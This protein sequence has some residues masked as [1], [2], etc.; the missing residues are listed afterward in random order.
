MVDDGS[1]LPASEFGLEGWPE[2][3]PFPLSASDCLALCRGDAV[4]WHGT[5]DKARLLPGRYELLSGWLI[6]KR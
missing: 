2:G 4:R 1:I 6:L 3:A 5:I